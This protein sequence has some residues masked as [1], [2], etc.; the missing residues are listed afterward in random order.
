[1]GFAEF[2]WA[3]P[4]F[5]EF[6]FG[7]YLVLQSFTQFKLFLPGFCGFTELFFTE[8][9]LVYVWVLPSFVGLY[10]VLPSFVGFYLFL[11]SFT[12]FKLFLPSFCGLIEFLGFLP[13]FT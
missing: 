7:F 8:F 5:T 13:S 11:S 10:L 4:K 3:L 2:C 6:F 9:Y 1:M 12:K